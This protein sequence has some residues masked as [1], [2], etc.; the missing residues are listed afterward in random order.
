MQNNI[1]LGRLT[2]DPELRVTSNGK[3]IALFTIAINNKKDDTTFLELVAFNN[4]A[5]NICK[6]CEKGSRILVNFTI[7]N[8][9][10]EKDGKKYYGY[11]FNVNSINF[12]DFK[13]KE[14][15]NSIESINMDDII[16]TDEELPFD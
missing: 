16:I 7:R 6:Y 15:S 12:I 5:E 14:K 8:N 10:Y 11:K 4:I 3:T 2:K 1:I 9:N 13:E